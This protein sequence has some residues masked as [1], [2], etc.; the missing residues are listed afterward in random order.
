MSFFENNGTIYEGTLSVHGD[1]NTLYQNNGTITLPYGLTEQS[2]YSAGFA[3]IT[4]NG[5]IGVNSGGLTVESS[6]A[7]GAAEILNNTA[8]TITVNGGG[9]A[10]EA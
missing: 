3:K 4:N 7:Y 6:L 8:G 10:A 2:T 1:S 9:L 5:S